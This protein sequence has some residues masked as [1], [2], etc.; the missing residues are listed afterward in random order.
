[1]LF[2]LTVHWRSSRWIELQ[3]RQLRRHANTDHVVHACLT[4]VEPGFASRFDRVIETD[5]VSHGEKLNLLAADAIAGGAADDDV[6]LFL[7][8]DAFPLAPLEPK[9]SAYLERWSMV[10]IRQDESAGDRQP[11][12][13]FCAVT[14]RR[15]RQLDGDWRPGHHWQLA[16]G[17]WRTDAGGNLLRQL[18][19]HGIDWHPLLRTAGLGRHGLYYGVYDDWIYHHGAGFRPPYSTFDLMQ[20]PYSR[21]LFR[22]TPTRWWP[23][24]SRVLEPTRR[25]IRR[26][27]D[28]SEAVFDR[29][30]GELLHGR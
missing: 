10:A 9:L 19:Q 7:D 8:G 14:V 11:H 20:N 17:R 23:R 22:I 24:V 2:V 15:W 12:P 25:T 30:V 6:L 29:L 26:N 18:E 16:N 27:R 3:T 28:E 13:S 1:M 4:G 21:L 5:L